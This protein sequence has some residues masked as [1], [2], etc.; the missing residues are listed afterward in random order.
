MILSNGNA[1]LRKSRPQ[2]FLHNIEYVCSNKHMSWIQGKSNRLFKK[3]CYTYIHDKNLN[4]NN[5]SNK[6]Y[7]QHSINKTPIVTVE[8]PIAYRSQLLSFPASFGGFPRPITTDCSWILSEL[9]FDSI[10][11]QVDCSFLGLRYSCTVIWTF[12][13]VVDIK[14]YRKVNPIEESWP[15]KSWQSNWKTQVR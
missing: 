3:K 8:I 9:V 12:C 7:C 1:N 13:W 5:N 4:N 2:P 15:L 6:R 14:S 11:I 10:L